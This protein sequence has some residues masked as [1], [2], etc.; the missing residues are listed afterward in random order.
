MKEKQNTKK[1]LFYFFVVNL[2]EKHEKSLNFNFLSDIIM[3][4]VSFVACLF[5][6]IFK[7]YLFINILYRLCFM[8]ENIKI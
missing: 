5:L 7:H 2:R 3:L 8:N 4:A 6:Y 1:N